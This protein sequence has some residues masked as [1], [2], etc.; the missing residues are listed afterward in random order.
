V[1]K[2]KIVIKLSAKK[3]IE[4]IGQKKDQER[5]ISKIRSLAENARPNRCGKLLG[6]DN[7]YRV[8]QGNYRIIY[9]VDDRNLTLDI[10]KVGN[11]RDVYQ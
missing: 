4:V 5:I 3:E 6:E 11:R 2:Y 7:K 9:S 1:G 8:R 10:W